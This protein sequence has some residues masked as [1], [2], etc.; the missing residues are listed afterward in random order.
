[1]VFIQV[2][3]IKGGELFPTGQILCRKMILSPESPWDFTEQVF[4]GGFLRRRSTKQNETRRHTPKQPGVGATKEDGLEKTRQDLPSKWWGQPPKW[5]GQQK[6]ID[7]SKRWFCPSIH[8]HSIHGRILIISKCWQ[9]CKIAK[10]V[11]W[12]VIN[13]KFRKKTYNICAS[14][15]QK[16]LFVTCKRFSNFNWHLKTLQS[17]ASSQMFTPPLWEVLHLEAA[18]TVAQ[19]TW[20]KSNGE[21][22][23]R[24]FDD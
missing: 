13:A 2:P 20:R 4:D 6:K 18:R 17:P 5:W 11:P 15:L 22:D 16:K 24:T 21:F 10:L 3:T 23:R 19:Q 8:L 9:P 12:L 7:K 14:N 1:M